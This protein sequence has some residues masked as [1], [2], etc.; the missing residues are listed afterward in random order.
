MIRRYRRDEINDDG[1]NGVYWRTEVAARV[2]RGES[3]RIVGLGTLARKPH[4]DAYAIRGVY[5]LTLTAAVA[6]TFAHDLDADNDRGNGVMRDV[7]HLARAL[8]A[9]VEVWSPGRPGTAWRDFGGTHV[10]TVQP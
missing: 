4:L 3:V 2:R 5:R 1:V 10:T 7:R 9:P 6:K 8:G